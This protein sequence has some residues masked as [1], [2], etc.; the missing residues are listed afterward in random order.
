MSEVRAFAASRF[1][2][3]GRVWICYNT[4]RRKEMKRAMPYSIVE[5]KI[6]EISP[7]YRGEL[8]A[9]IDFL[10]LRGQALQGAR[11]LWGWSL[12]T[13]LRK[14]AFS[15]GTDPFEVAAANNFRESCKNFYNSFTNFLQSFYNSFTTR[16]GGS[17]IFPTCRRTSA[18]E[19]KRHGKIGK[20]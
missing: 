20:G 7:Q 10:K 11:F 5:D 3:H 12:G 6:A 13:T 1:V 9:F 8:L 18:A 4:R 17:A 2:R 15:V 19:R 16:S 14:A